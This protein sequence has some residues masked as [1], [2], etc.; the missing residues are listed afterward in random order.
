MSTPR[1]SVAL[2]AAAASLLA[3]GRHAEKASLP[4]TAVA[5]GRAV[6]VARPASRIE[7][8]LARVTGTIRAKDD[9]V[10][11]AKATGQIRRIRVDV[12]DRVRAGQPLV[13][14]DAT[15]AQI[16]LQTAKAA[17]RL[18]SANL[19]QAESEVARSKALHDQGVLPDAA[20]ERVQTARELAAAQLDQARAGVRQA[21]QAN[22]DAVITAPFAGVVTEKYRNAGD[23]VTLMPVTPI[24][25]LTDLDHLE[26]RLSLPESLAGFVKPGQAVEGVTTP[27]DRRFP[28]TVRVKGSVVDPATR[29]IEVLADVGKVEGEPLRPGTL[30]DVDFGGF[31][32]RGAGL[33]IPASA[34]RTDGDASWVLVVASGKAER[35]PVE[36]APVNP[37]VVAVKRGVDASSE[38]ILDPG[39]LAPGDAVV[40]LA[41]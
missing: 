41:N 37:G 23:T 5:A 14:M 12:G 36:I 32:D 3:C 30:V 6:R 40:P 8:G 39:A 31:G 27:G 13:E 22:V 33:F 24:L 20:W 11:A 35:R 29:T 9:A 4:T 28:M 18:A 25:A 26:V 1:T 16:A 19:A 10:L 21:E 15:N 7:T 34:L 17:E 38:V 2:A